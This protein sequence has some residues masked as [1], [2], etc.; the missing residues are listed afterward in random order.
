MGYHRSSSGAVLLVSNK[1][2]NAFDDPLTLV[3]ERDVGRLMRK[4]LSASNKDIGVLFVY[5]SYEECIR[6]GSCCD[7]NVFV[8]SNCLLRK[9]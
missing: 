6:K 2:Y 8:S 4:M 3:E 9:G 1:S 5:A 7:T